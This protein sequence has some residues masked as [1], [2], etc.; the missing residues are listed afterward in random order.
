MHRSVD[1]PMSI[2]DGDDDADTSLGATTPST[3]L[4]LPSTSF[5][6]SPGRVVHRRQSRASPLCGPGSYHGPRGDMA[7]WESE[8]Q[9]CR[10]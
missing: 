4:S 5:I 8:N 10:H 9:A 1:S 6:V 2:V 3:A 7:S